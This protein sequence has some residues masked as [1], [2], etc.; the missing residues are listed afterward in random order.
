MDRIADFL[1]EVKTLKE[2]SRAGYAFLG[3]GSESVAEHSFMTAVIAFT[4]SRMEPDVN[5]GRLVAMA[6]VHDFS[7][8]RTGDLNYV[9]KRYVKVMEQKAMDDLT[10]GLAFGGDLLDLMEEFNRG[11]TLEAM[12]A[13]DADQI[14]FV[15]ELKKNSDNGATSPRKWLPHVL[16]R[17]K[18]RTGKT[19]A[20]AVMSSNWDHWWQK[21][22]TEQG[23]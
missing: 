3:T 18:T 14:S 21:N 19:L 1:F 12:L 10:S 2:L 23:L 7:E 6:L 11:E 5:G 16:A 22:Y 17:L 13:N 8:A 4:M 20:E 9:Q 15:M